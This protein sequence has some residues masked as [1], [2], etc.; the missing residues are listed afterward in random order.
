MKQ[1][2]ISDVHFQMLKDIGKKWRMTPDELIE[3]LIQE[4]YA[5]KSKRK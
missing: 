3:E 2:K 4:T 1:I 5:N